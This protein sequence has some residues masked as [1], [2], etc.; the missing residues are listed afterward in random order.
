MPKALI[1][2]AASNTSVGRRVAV[3]VV[4][5]L[6]ELMGLPETT[7]VFLP[8]NTQAIPLNNAEFGNCCSAKHTYPGDSRMIVTVVEDAE[9]D[10]ALTTSVNDKQS[11]PIIEDKIHNVSVTPV[12]RY[13]KM[14]CNIEFVAASTTQAQ[15]WLD[16]MRA[17]F[18][19][20]RTEQLHDLEYYYQ[21]PD[22]M[23]FV[24]KAC[25]DAL[26]KSPWPLTDT[27]EDWVLSKLVNGAYPKD[28]TTLA[29]THH[30][31]AIAEHQYDALG[32]FDWTTTPDTPERNSD[33]SGTF[34]V[35]LNYQLQY[36]RPTHVY[37]DYPFVLNQY[38]ISKKFR[39]TE[40]Y[41]FYRDRLRKVSVTKEAFDEFRFIQDQAGTVPYV[42]Y[43]NTNDWY[44]PPTQKLGYALPLFTGLVMLSAD[45]QQTLVDL[46]ALGNC[47]FMPHFLEY[48]YAQGD[49]ALDDLQGMFEFRLWKNNTHQHGQKFRFKPGTLQIQT[50]EP[51]D[52]QYM[53]HIQ[54]CIK[55]NWALVHPRV[56]QCL[57]NWPTVAYTLLKAI[58]VRLGG[59][60]LLED[61][62]LLAPN[63]PRANVAPCYGEGYLLPETRPVEVNWGIRG[64]DI[65]IKNG[66]VKAKDMEQAIRD[67]DTIS[68][69]YIN[70]TSIGP[71][72]VMFFDILTFRNK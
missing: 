5:H 63:T 54:I 67:T 23:T 25:H 4:Q 30:T 41:W 31:L 71:L 69:N 66:M 20:G 42:H 52:P 64:T 60:A 68:D 26:M 19:A 7:Q 12:Y 28:L 17:M 44:P 16:D 59:A 36:G 61:L 43:P 39:F 9:E 2:L 57:R 62:E 34:T 37:V 14:T 3:H 55:R 65:F 70:H 72:T 51:L 6:T 48:F 13:V 11:R 32:W 49:A 38:P 21:L 40:P 53:Y 50:V 8:G 24:L 27:F 35:N 22:G 29:G 47:R 45:D 15:R 58:G 1:P 56:I 33:G 10:H 46:S 18:S